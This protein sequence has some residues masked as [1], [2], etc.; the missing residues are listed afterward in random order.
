MLDEIYKKGM[1]N[2][3]LAEAIKAKGYDD[4]GQYQTSYF[5][6]YPEV[7]K[8][9]QT[10]VCDS[11]EPKSINDLRGEGLKVI[12][13]QKF[14]G[15]VLYGIKWLQNRRIVID[16]ARTPNAH[17]EFISYEYMTTKDGEFLAD[18]PDKDNHAIDA[19]RYALDRLINNRRI[20]A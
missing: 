17:R 19:T 4:T 18:V 3:Q 20:S 13:C 12:A 11:A 6:G 15:S 5:S 10:I 7:F 1:S 16:P 9:R 8:E 14:P 2:K